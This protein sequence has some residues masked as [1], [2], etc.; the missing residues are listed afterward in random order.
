[1]I[2]S[3]AHSYLRNEALPALFIP[4]SHKNDKKIFKG[5]QVFTDSR[6][7]FYYEFLGV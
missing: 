1:M 7:L 2:D 6:T 5:N 4:K 3:K